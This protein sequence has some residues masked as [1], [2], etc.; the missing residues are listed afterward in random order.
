MIEEIWLHFLYSAC[1]LA[2]ILIGNP[3]HFTLITPINRKFAKTKRI[4]EQI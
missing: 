1:K 4:P 3:W 2:P